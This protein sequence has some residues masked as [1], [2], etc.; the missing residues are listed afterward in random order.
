MKQFL[1]CLRHPIVW[2]CSFIP[3]C[4]RLEHIQDKWFDSPNAYRPKKRKR[5]N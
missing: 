3:Y 5:H 1:W 4:D 2:V